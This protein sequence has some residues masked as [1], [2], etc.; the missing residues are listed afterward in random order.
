[1]SAEVDWVLGQLQSVVNAQPTNPDHPLR[2]VDRDDSEILEGNIRDHTGELRQANFVG[3]SLADE[4]SSPSGSQYD[5]KYERVVGLRIEGLHES[6]YGHIDPDGADGVVWETLKDD[7]RRAILT[8]RTFPNAG[9][10]TVTYTDVQ[11]ANP[12]PQSD[13]WAD[14][15]RYDVDLVFRGYEELP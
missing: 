3:A 1:M 6:K 13:N 7:I 11:L 9:R 5:H 12:A 10:S 4:N 8:D 15:Y 2:R 14:Y